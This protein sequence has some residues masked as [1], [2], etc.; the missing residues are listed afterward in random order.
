MTS[1]QVM[2]LI[3]MLIG[4]IGVIGSY[5]QGLIAHP[6]SVNI[7]GKNQRSFLLCLYRFHAPFGAGLFRFRLLFVVQN[8]AV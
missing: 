4:G 8:C 6:G 3:V 2:L 5:V 7:L 1:S